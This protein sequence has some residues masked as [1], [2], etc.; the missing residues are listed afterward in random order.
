MI[1]EGIILFYTLLRRR[2]EATLLR[3]Y[4]LTLAHHYEKNSFFCFFS[5][6]RKRST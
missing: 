6:S 4:S 3:H 5:P 2:N 1:A